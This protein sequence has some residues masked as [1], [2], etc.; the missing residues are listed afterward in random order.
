MAKHHAVITVGRRKNAVARVHLTPIT[1]GKGMNIEIN[2]KTFEKFFPNEIHR[3]DVVRP[4]K[5]T[6]QYGNYSVNANVVGGGTSGQAGAVRLAIAHSLVGLNEEFRA[7]LRKEDLMTRD[8]RM[9]ERKKPG[10]PKA[11]KRFQFSKR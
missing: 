10:Q 6:G 8:P 11:R 1:D 4:L 9:V 5:A 7:M 3:E 2:G